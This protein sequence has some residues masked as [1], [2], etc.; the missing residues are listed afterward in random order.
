M[1]PIF[2]NRGFSMLVVAAA[3][4]PHLQLLVELAEFQ[5][6]GARDGAPQWGLQAA[7]L[8]PPQLLQLQAELL[9]AQHGRLQL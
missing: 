1:A 5:G 6:G 3:V 2:G 7:Q 4:S 9:H 8:A